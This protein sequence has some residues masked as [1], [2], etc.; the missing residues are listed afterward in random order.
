LDLLSYG[1][2]P[3]PLLKEDF[4]NANATFQAQI[5]LVE[6]LQGEL[7]LLFLQGQDLRFQVGKPADQISFL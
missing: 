4:Q 7:G 6:Q 5:L 1:S 2:L 3:H